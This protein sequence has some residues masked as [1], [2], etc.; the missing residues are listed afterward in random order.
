M[1]GAELVKLTYCFSNK[2]TI[3]RYDNKHGLSV[4]MLSQGYRDPGLL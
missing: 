4:T 2:M 3:G 1:L